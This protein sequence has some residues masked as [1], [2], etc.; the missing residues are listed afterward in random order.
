MADSK[1]ALQLM[2]LSLL[3]FF[4]HENHEKARKNVVA[5]RLAWAFRVPSGRRAVAMCSFAFVF[6]RGFRG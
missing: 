1:R 2:G 3:G 4:G 6:F 5:C